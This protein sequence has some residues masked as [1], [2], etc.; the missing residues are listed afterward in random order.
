[1]NQKKDEMKKKVMNA[2]ENQEQKA[3]NPSKIQGTKK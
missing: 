1:L 2:N 3:S